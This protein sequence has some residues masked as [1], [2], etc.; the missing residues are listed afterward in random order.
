MP[1]IKLGLTPQELQGLRAA[2]I[3]ISNLP[4]HSIEELALLLGIPAIRAMEILALAEFQSIPS[5][6]IKFA[7]DMI[8]LGYYCLDDLKDKE[9][10]KLIEDLELATGAWI[11]PCVEDQCRLI[12]DYANN[13]D[14]SKRW[15]DFTEER[16]K[17]RAANGYP[18]NRPKNAWF[19][20]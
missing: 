9:G 19:E 12:V 6:G 7:K 2:K 14:D 5:I 1:N 15:W 18:A 17:Y 4:N 8:S 16:K 3:K 10:S 13:R 11:D 20:V